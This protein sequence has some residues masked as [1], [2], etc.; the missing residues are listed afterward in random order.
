MNSV[1]FCVLFLLNARWNCAEASK[2]LF[3]VPI[4][5]YSCVRTSKMPPHFSYS[6]FRSLFGLK[7]FLFVL[8]TVFYLNWI[9]LMCF[10]L[11]KAFREISW[12]ALF[13]L[14]PIAKFLFWLKT[15]Q[16]LPRNFL[17]CFRQFYTLQ[18]I[19]FA[20]K[21]FSS[22]SSAFGVLLWPEIIGLLS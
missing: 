22:A 15:A 3:L 18:E 21:F 9:F 6:C 1:L 5:L 11:P 16:G 4:F 20:S 7:K 14:Q 17:V 8:Y 12:L 10:I 19:Y 13:Y 2:F